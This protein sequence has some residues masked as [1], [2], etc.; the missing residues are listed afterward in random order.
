MFWEV[1][2]ERCRSP[3][4]HVEKE[5]P[6]GGSQNVSA[7]ER[8]GNLTGGRQAVISYRQVYRVDTRF[9]NDKVVFTRIS[10]LIQTSRP[11]GG[12]ERLYS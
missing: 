5:A 12:L 10:N 9:F 7:R 1:H 8:F 6:I 11:S 4:D 2:S 3:R